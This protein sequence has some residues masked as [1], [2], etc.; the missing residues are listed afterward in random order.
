[1]DFNRNIDSNRFIRAVIIVALIITTFVLTILYVKKAS[2]DFCI[3]IMGDYANQLA[4]QIK[5]DIDNDTETLR[6]AAAAISSYDEADVITREKFFRMTSRDSGLSELAMLFPDDTMTI[7]NIY[8]SELEGKLSYAEE[9][10]KAPYISGTGMVNDNPEQK[11]IYICEPVIREN[12]A[13]GLLYGIIDLKDMADRYSVT[14]YDGKSSHY[15]IDGENGDFLL[16]TWHNKLGNTNDAAYQGR[17]SKSGYNIENIDKELSEGRSEYSVFESKTTGEYLYMYYAPIGIKT[18]SAIVSVPEDVVMQ[19]AVEITTSLYLLMAV[20]VCVLIG[21]LYLEWRSMNKHIIQRD[22]ELKELKSTHEMVKIA[23]ETDALTGI[24]NRNSYQELLKKYDDDYEFSLACV[25]IDANGLHDINNRFGHEAG[26]KM[27]KFIASLLVENF[28]NDYVFRIGGDEFV[29]I[30]ENINENELEEKINS[31]NSAMK[32]SPYRAAIG[33]ELRDSAEN[34]GRIIREAE[35]KMY[36][37]K[38][39]HYGSIGE[40]NKQRSI[41]ERL[42]GFYAK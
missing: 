41:G 35:I 33:Y 28:E 2:E 6:I 11:Y 5:N 21:Y 3:R 42:D 8:Y 40:E 1:M 36:K 29:V 38:K 39:E 30:S 20:L 27:L 12:E 16:D 37:D 31:F 18:W 22:E 24:K 7:S 25:Y 26:D 19:S 17:K 4:V 14:M 23:A 32:K 9:L 13:I 15:I 10:K 34:A